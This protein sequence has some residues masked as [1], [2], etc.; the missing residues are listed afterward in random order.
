MGCLLGGRDHSIFGAVH[1]IHKGRPSADDATAEC[2]WIAGALV[3]CLRT[4]GRDGDRA[5][6]PSHPAG[7]TALV[8]SVRR[9]GQSV[10]K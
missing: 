5:G 8:A 7:Q 10:F 3:T 2:G 4:Q 6:H 1:M 9:A